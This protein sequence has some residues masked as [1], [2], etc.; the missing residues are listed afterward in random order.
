MTHN[1]TNL[2]YS[3]DF[4]ISMGNGT[5]ILKNNNKRLNY[6]LT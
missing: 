6:L 1:F 5:K 2:Y 3:P 4:I